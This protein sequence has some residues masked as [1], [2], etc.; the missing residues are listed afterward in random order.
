MNKMDNESF[1]QFL[2]LVADEY[3]KYPN[4]RFG[5]TLY[6]VLHDIR[7]ELA[8]SIIGTENDPFYTDSQISGFISVVLE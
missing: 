5:Q 4:L 1:A 3:K 7:P 6:N 8:E 2:K